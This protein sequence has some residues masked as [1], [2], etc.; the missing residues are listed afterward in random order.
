MDGIDYLIYETLRAQISEALKRHSINKQRIE[1][2]VKLKNALSEL[3]LSNKLLTKQSIHDELTGIYNRRGFFVTSESYFEE[4][5]KSDSGFYVIF[6]DIDGLKYINDNFG[7][8][9]GDFAIK[10]IT[11][12]INKVLNFPS[13]NQ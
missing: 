4:A 7:H 2:E 6:G 8:K 13:R 12:L 5:I 9:E 1:A 3:E 10:K 11:E